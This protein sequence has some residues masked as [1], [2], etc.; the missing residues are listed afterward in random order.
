LTLP[1][2][3]QPHFKPLMLAPMSHQNHHLPLMPTI[4][5]CCPPLASYSHHLPHNLCLLP[6]ITWLWCPPF[7]STTH[8]SPWSQPFAS[9]NCLLHPPVASTAHYLPMAS[10]CVCCPPL[11]STTHQLPPPIHHLASAFAPFAFGVY[12]VPPL[13]TTCLCCPPLDYV[14]PHSTPAHTT[15]LH[16]T[17]L[18]SSTHHSTPAHTTSLQLTP[19][20]SGSCHL[21]PP[22]TTRLHCNVGNQSHIPAV[23]AKIFCCVEAVLYSPPQLQQTPMIMLLH[24]FFV[25]CSLSFFC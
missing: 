2:T 5:L 13:S 20:T 18:N 12:H 22:H 24:S 15:Q 16:H 21:T 9:S 7:A 19:L 1:P 23:P 11:D 10:T 4:L 3:T 14:A 25:L 6:S 17:S 8:H